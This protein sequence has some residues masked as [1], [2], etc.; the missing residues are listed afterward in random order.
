[1]VT[2]KSIFLEVLI[3]RLYELKLPKDNPDFK[4]LFVGTLI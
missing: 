1:M 2:S 4:E 3:F